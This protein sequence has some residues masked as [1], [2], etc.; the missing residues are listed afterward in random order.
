MR[1]PSKANKVSARVRR[2]P[3]NETDAVS[4]VRLPKE[5][6]A[7]IDNWAEKHEVYRSE[8][9]RQ[10]VE[11]GLTVKPSRAATS[12]AAARAAELA[13]EVIDSHSDKSAPPMEQESR[14]HRLL[15]GPSA[16]QDMRKDRSK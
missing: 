15:K 12:K 4:A 9:I 7:R 11:L 6:T 10:L 13:S 16:F 1:S 14:K 3:A 2:K 8:A 5:L